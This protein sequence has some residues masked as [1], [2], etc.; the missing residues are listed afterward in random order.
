MG[1]GP[2]KGKAK[3][4]EVAFMVVV[5]WVLS[6]VP[7]ELEAKKERAAW[8]VMLWVDGQRCSSGKGFFGMGPW[9]LLGG[10]WF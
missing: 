6:V 5:V 9:G 7:G 4:G 2:P 3:V 10:V 1:L 8:V